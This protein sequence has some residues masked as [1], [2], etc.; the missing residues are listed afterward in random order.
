MVSK[1]RLRRII[2]T[3]SRIT[4]SFITRSLHLTSY[5]VDAEDFN[6]D[7][8]GFDLPEYKHTRGIQIQIFNLPHCPLGYLRVH[9]EKYRQRESNVS[10]ECLPASDSP[11]T[12]KLNSKP[13]E[14]LGF[15]LS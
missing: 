9:Q 13:V 15:S 5:A 4:T 2:L 14:K 11:E 12:L 1:K 3:I 8:I 6:K 7:Q 10:R